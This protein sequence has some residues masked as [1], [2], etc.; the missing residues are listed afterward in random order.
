MKVTTQNNIRNLKTAPKIAQLGYSRLKNNLPESFLLLH[1]QKI[2][3]VLEGSTQ[4]S[5]KIPRNQRDAPH[6]GRQEKLNTV[7]HR[8]LHDMNGPRWSCRWKRVRSTLTI[9]G[10][11][12]FRFSVFLLFLPGAGYHAGVWTPVLR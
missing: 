1:F 5:L 3:A 9:E 2:R 12:P 4:I 10:L 6:V 11:C 7:W 8:A